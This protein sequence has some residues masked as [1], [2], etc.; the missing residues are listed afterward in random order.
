MFEPVN[1][2]LSRVAALFSLTGC[3]TQAFACVFENAPFVILGN[4]PYL[5]V[6]TG[7]Q[8]RAL[9]Y[10]S[11]KM[12]SQAYS[13]SLVFF[14]FYGVLI[15][16]LAFKSTFLPRVLGILMAIAGAG[17]LTFFSPPLGARLL[18]YLMVVGIGEALLALWL[19]VAGVNAERWMEQARASA[20]STRE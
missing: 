14:A 6:F 7:D 11:L 5:S 18:P 13:I 1:P 8:L 3:T 9:A 19:L 17:W 15:G 20:E 2:S 4:A 12:Y 16:A 10:T